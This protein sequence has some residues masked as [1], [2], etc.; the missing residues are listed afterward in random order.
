MELISMIV[1]CYNE[2]QSL[3]H[4][5]NAFKALSKDMS[6]VNFEVIFV[7]DGSK[8]D[9]INVIKSL[10]KDDDRVK[11]ISFSRNFG[12]ES[13]MFAG[14]EKA[15]GD[16][17][18]IIDADLQ[19]P[20][21]MIKTMYENIQDGYDC[22]GAY[23]ISRTGEPKIRSFF[24]NQF[25]KLVN[26]ISDVEIVNGAC[27]YRLM[28][29]PVIDA[30]T[31]LKE[32]NRFTKGIFSFVGFDTKWLPY[33]NE[34]RVAG[35]TTW[36]FWGLFKYSIE[37]IMA[38][39]TTPLFFASLLGLIVCFCSFLFIIATIIKTLVFGE[40]AI[41]YPTLICAITFLGG[42]Q[43][44]SIGILGQYIG[45]IYLESKKRPIYI[46]KEEK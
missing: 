24:A 31:S 6:A 29:R 10:A 43:L 33:E 44:F 15:I 2:E 35:E 3:P 40:V 9:T 18:V 46:V 11:F 34:T 45:K 20:P 7:N 21:Q 36:S 13:A 30:I 14:L 42:V 25:Y 26:K 4:F 39:S 12:K 38:F 41:G 28:R 37:G 16:Y 8:D 17:A 19:H 27:D 32:Y 5:Y 22:V 1:P 23:R